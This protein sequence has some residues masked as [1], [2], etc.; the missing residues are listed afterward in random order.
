MKEEL[1]VEEDEEDKV[2]LDEERL[3]LLV[4]A[5]VPPELEEE[6]RMEEDEDPVVPSTIRPLE[7]L[8]EPF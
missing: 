3:E 1:A 7:L 8:P 6:D 5:L 2:P 4:L